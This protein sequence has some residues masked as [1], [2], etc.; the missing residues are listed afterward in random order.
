MNF[1]LFPGKMLL[2]KN[3]PYSELFWPLLSR[4]RTKYGEISP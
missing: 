4:I 2:R 3:G 1:V